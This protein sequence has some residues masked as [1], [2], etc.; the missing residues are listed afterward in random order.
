MALIVIVIVAYLANTRTDRSTSSIY[1]N[2]LKAK[3]MAESGLTAATKLLSDNTKYG[4]YI[5]AMPAPSPS[6]VPLYSEVYRPADPADSNHG[7]KQ[8]D[9]LTLANAAGEILASR[10]LTVAPPAPQVDPRPTPEVIPTPLP[11]SSPFAISSPIP[12]FSS[13]NSYDFNQI[14]RIGTNSSARLV[15]PRLRHL[16]HPH[17]VSGSECGTAG[18]ILS[19]VMRSSSKTKA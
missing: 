6:P 8:G 11:A 18:E 13:S 15:Q 16:P 17:L 5:T 2:Q 4:N 7:A 10:A 3:M 12:A 1:A 19:V 14:V 9:Y